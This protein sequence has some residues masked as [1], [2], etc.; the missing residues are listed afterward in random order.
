VATAARAK[1]LLQ[2]NIPRFNKDEEKNFKVIREIMQEYQKTSSKGA[3][4][5]KEFQK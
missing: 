3:Q 5:E 1:K 4:L 2:L